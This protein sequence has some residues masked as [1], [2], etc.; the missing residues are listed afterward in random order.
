MMTPYPISGIWRVGQ[1]RRATVLAKERAGRLVAS[2]CVWRYC[3]ELAPHCACQWA[4]ACGRGLGG[5]QG[6]GE[7]N[8]RNP[9]RF[10]FQLSGRVLCREELTCIHRDILVVNDKFSSNEPHQEYW[11][12]LNKPRVKLTKAWPEPGSN[13]VGKALLL[14][15]FFSLASISVVTCCEPTFSTG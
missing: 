14:S 9:P 5:Q 15:L 6:A 10:L 3:L 8:A 13:E 7:E 11:I 1:K 4:G 12:L 2:V